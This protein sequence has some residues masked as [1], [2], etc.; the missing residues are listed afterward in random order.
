MSTPDATPGPTRL[1]TLLPKAARR[2]YRAFGFVEAAVVT[3]WR[4]IVGPMLAD[5]SLPE[6]LRFAPGKRRDGTLQIRVDGGFAL[7]VQHYAPLI[8]ER[9]NRY[10]G[11]GAVARLS[12]KQGPLPP[13]PQ[14]LAKPQVPLTAAARQ[15]IESATD[16]IVDD[17]LK[18]SLHRLGALIASGKEQR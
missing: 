4:H 3:Q 11:Y 16:G 8:I 7:E 17:K 14:S 18:A 5:H 6:R 9:V 10:F 2:A 15:R 12:I 13:V 1:D